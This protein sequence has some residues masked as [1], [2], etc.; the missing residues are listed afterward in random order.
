MDQTVDK[1]RTNVLL[2]EEYHQDVFL[3]FQKLTKPADNVYN[4]WTKHT[5]NYTVGHSRSYRPQWGHIRRTRG[6]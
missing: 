6:P 3:G 5:L 1:L 2:M 4:L